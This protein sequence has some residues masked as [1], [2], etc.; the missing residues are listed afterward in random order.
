[1]AL[2]RGA[3]MPPPYE[4]RQK[5][6]KSTQYPALFTLFALPDLISHATPAHY[7]STGSIASYTGLVPACYLPVDDK[8]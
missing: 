5:H 8:E 4:Q 6:G 7:K 1:M 3:G 2:R